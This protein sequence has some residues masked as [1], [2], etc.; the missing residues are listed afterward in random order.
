M[1]NLEL[2]HTLNREDMSD[3]LMRLQLAPVQYNPYFPRTTGDWYK[4]LGQ[5]AKYTDGTPPRFWKGA[6]T[7][8]R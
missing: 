4:W 5:E 7:L 2:L 6:I 8:N 3:L 1:T